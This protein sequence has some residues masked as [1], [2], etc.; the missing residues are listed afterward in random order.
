MESSYREIYTWKEPDGW[1]SEISRVFIERNFE[2]IKSRL[3]ELNKADED[4]FISLDGLNPFIY[5][6]PEF[7]RYLNNCGEAKEWQ[8]PVM[9]IVINHKT[10]KDSFQDHFEFLRKEKEYKTYQ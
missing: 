3:A 5:E 9:S 10:E 2:L 8:Y 4:Y 1:T 7:E 6:E